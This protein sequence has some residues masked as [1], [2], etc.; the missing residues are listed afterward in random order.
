MT[1]LEATQEIETTPLGGERV[2][3]RPSFPAMK[4]PVVQAH[5]VKEFLR[6]VT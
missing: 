6:I 1:G 4:F 2:P 3:D 5:L